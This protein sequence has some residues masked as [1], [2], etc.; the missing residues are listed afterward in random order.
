MNAR[1]LRL[2]VMLLSRVVFRSVLLG[3]GLAAAPLAAFAQSTDA[4]AQS[5]IAS[6]TVAKVAEAEV[7]GRIPVSGTLVPRD[8][9]LVYPQVN[10]Y[11]IDE[12]RVD[13]GDS[14]AKGDI[15]AV[16]NARTL[17]AQ[18]AQS[19]AE[20]ARA[21]ANTS[22]AQSQITSAEATATQAESVLER[23]R[24]LQRNGATTQAA[25]DQAIATAQSAAASLASA[26]DGLLVARAQ[27]QTAQAQLDI[28]QLGLEHAT[29]RAP[30]AG[31]ISARNGQIG[32]IAASAGEP[33]YRIIAGGIIE[34]EAEV[35]ETA[36]GGLQ[37]GDT[38]DLTI[39]PFF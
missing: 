1:K 32:A 4:P 19:Q 35:I 33:I 13:I 39:A 28:A 9:I 31:L 38:A 6:V 23:T 3:L 5:N 36:L 16:L 29:L 34:V 27:E 21:K 7:V 2:Q 10:G 22:Q 30:V 11:T 8:E 14:V 37:V 18:L 17:E 12:L 15:L 25:L 20:L 24:Q 26:Q